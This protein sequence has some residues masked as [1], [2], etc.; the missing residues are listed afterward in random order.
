MIVTD[1]KELRLFDAAQKERWE[2]PAVMHGNPAGTPLV[3]DANYIFASVQGDV[4]SL[5]AATG[6]EVGSIH[7]GEPLGAGPVAYQERLLLCGND[8]TLHVI[9]T[10]SANSTSATGAGGQ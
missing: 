9:P 5:V 1:A 2:K 8:G 7:V 6:Q 4:W 10:P 3:A